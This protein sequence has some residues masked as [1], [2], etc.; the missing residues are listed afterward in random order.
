MPASRAKLVPSIIEPTVLL[1]FEPIETVSLGKRW[2]VLLS[3]LL[4]PWIRMVV[5]PMEWAP[6]TLA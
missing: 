4:E 5:S 2:L 6:E 3:A 1:P